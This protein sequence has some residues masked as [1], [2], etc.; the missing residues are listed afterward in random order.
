MSILTLL[1]AGDSY[2]GPPVADIMVDGTA[3]PSVQIT[4]ARTDPSQAV[5]LTL[6]P[7]GHTVTVAF[8]DD[9]YGGPGHDRN[10]ILRGA[11]LDGYDTHLPGMT[12]V[13]NGS[14]SFVVLAPSPAETAPTAATATPDP[15]LAAIAALKADVDAGFAAMATLPATAPSS[16]AGATVAPSTLDLSALPT[17]VAGGTTT[18]AAGTY[19]NPLH[20]PVPQTIQGQGMRKTILDGRKGV[21]GGHRL[22]WGKGSIHAGAPVLI[23]DIGF[24][25]GGGGDGK[26]D[27]EAGAY[28]EGF[29]GLMHLLR[30][31][32]DGNE[33]GVFLPNVSLADVDLLIEACVFGRNIPNG[34]ADESSHN[35]YASGKSV[36]IR[37]SI[38]L[39]SLANTIKIRGPRLMLEDSYLTRLGRWVDCPGGTVAVSN[40][41]T[42]VTPPDCPSQNAF[43]FYDEGDGNANP[44]QDGSFTSTDDTFY[45][46]RFH[47]VIW[48]NNPATKVQFI[49]PKVHWIGPAGSNPPGV[50]IQGPGALVGDNPFVF[51]A[52]NRVDAAPPIPD[53]PVAPASTLLAA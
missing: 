26:S 31:A 4:A 16:S 5:S 22:A 45:F 43:G 14:Y 51:T 13:R 38:V 29:S 37:R 48:I 24:I 19:I 3:T 11:T 17:L 15:I 10:L 18:L 47:E 53:D 44:G 27:G 49:N 7:G 28:G 50:T 39:A 46:S 41:N 20:V 34:L 6:T 35:V 2:D 9:A 42:Y 40:R 32:F 8:N 1:F 25:N 30:C 36:T 33:N 21:G 23:S 12:F 52:E